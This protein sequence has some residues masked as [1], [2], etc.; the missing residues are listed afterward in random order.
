MHMYLSTKIDK[1]HIKSCIEK[2][3]T[4]EVPRK[5]FKE[6][7]SCSIDQLY[8]SSIFTSKEKTAFDNSLI[9]IPYDR[10]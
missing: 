6:L 5:K 10:V 1:T 9:K 2:E 7:N 4:K 8:L 3:A